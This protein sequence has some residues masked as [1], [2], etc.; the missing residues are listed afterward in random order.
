MLKKLQNSP[1]WKKND[2][3]NT[4]IASH[5]NTAPKKSEAKLDTW[6]LIGV[7][8]IIWEICQVYSERMRWKIEFRRQKLVV[9]FVT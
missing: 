3:S 2:E 8:G 9:A 7:P 6:Y 5:S 4:I 1:T